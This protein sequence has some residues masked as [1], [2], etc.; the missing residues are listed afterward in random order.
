MSA[1]D[2]KRFTALGREWTA[3]FD[4]NA[5][6]AIEERRDGRAFL[7]IVAPMLQRLD[8]KDRN[9]PAKQVAAASAIRFSDLRLILNQA[10][11]GAQA[12]T[13]VDETG[14]II[15]EIGL[16]ETMSIV[17]WAIGR[18]MGQAEGSEAAGDENPPAA[19]SGTARKAG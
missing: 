17:A 10:L 14:A 19:K 2:A 13:S 11:Q 1:I 18:G 15:A 5:I 8:E 4:F 7:E 9:N 16:T 3:R 6:C 12:G